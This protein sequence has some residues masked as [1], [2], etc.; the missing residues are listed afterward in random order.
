MIELITL[1]SSIIFIMQKYTNVNGFC[2]GSNSCENFFG[3]LKKSCGCDFSVPH[4][5]QQIPKMLE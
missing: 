5:V 2:I 4:A 3:R 1:T